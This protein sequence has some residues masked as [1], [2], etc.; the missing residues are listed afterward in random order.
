MSDYLKYTAEDFALDEKFQSWVLSP[1]ERAHLFWNDFLK[2][3][4]D[5]KKEIDEAVEL[6]RLAGLSADSQAN[7]A[8]LNT[9]ANLATNIKETQKSRGVWRYMPWA[10]VLAGVFVALIYLLG[11]KGEQSVEYRTGFAES[12]E[13]KLEDGSVVLLNA[14]SELR[15]S[16]SYAQ[17]KE[18]KVFLSGEAFFKVART[19]DHKSFTVSTEGRAMI[20]VLGTEFNVSSRRKNLSVYLQSG[21]VKLQ[22]ESNEVILQPGEK[23]DYNENSGKVEVNRVNTEQANSQLAWRSGLFIMNDLP[24]VEVAGYIED[25]FGAQVVI[26]D[27]ALGSKRITAKI[28]SKDLDVLLKVLSEG[29]N[30]KIERKENQI[31]M[32]TIQ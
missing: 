24:L 5:K 12:M 21:K 4:P 32:K 9:W 27:S 8:Y 2:E 29:L 22:V 20:Q 15:F 16:K 28:P 7:A 1:D 31:I 10:A 6:V 3:F 23:A 26:A 11:S 25:N 17:Q 18:R 30:I 19:E 13:I 14:N